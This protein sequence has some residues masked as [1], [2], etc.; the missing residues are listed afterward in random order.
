MPRDWTT[1]TVL[2]ELLN[3]N[4]CRSRLGGVL[5]AVDGDK[6]D[7]AEIKGTRWE[8][9]GKLA[10]ELEDGRWFRPEQLVLAS[11]WPM[12]CCQPGHW[13]A[14]NKRT[15]AMKAREKARKKSERKEAEEAKTK[16]SE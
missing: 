13:H 12:G 7:L 8:K 6:A 16:G 4:K 14:F 10:V 11:I 2:D 5:V 3:R 9:S 1:V 15:P